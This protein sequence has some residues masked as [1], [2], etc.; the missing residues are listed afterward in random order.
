MPQLS[1]WVEAGGSRPMTILLHS[2]PSKLGEDYARPLEEV[3]VPQGAFIFLKEEA[4]ELPPAEPGA[5]EHPAH[6]LAIVAGEV[7]VLI[8]AALGEGAVGGDEALQGGRA[9]GWW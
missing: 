8:G 5:A 1:P 2:S 9:S 7:G 6:R 3:A 4:L